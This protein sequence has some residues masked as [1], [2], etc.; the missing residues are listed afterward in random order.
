MKKITM[1]CLVLFVGIT[2]SQI[3][4][5]PDPEFEIY[6]L[7]IGVDTDGSLNGQVFTSD[8]EDEI[9][10][11]FPWGAP[12]ITDL[13]GIEDFTSIEILDLRSINITEL[14]ISNNL[15]LNKLTITDVSLES[16]DISNNSL[17]ETLFITLNSGGL[18]TS[19][20]SNLDLSNNVLLRSFDIS[21][22][23]ISEIDFSQ[24][25]NLSTL[26]IFR[27]EELTSINLKNGN[28][29][30]LNWVRIENNTVLECVQVDDPTAVIAGVDPPYDNWIIENDPIITDDCQLGVSDN[31]LA[32]NINI[33]PNPVSTTLTIDNNSKVQIKTIKIY[34]V[35]GRL[36][37][38]EKDRF[39]RIDVSQLT[40]G[41]LFVQLE[42]EQGVLTKKVIKE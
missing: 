16:L 29:I 8:I 2:Y 34:D 11:L 6:L 3:T 25:I 22:V 41:L 38:Q 27:S 5:I 14:N 9:D 15:I 18:F 40:S 35:L 12:E 7:N 4:L 17:L 37:L 32:N 26:E 31:I 19:P 10:L 42:T 1:F 30:N 20:I 21:G 13:T 36:V 23:N 28:N 39:T 33:Y 24:N